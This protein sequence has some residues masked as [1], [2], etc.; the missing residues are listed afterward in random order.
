MEN[1]EKARALGRERAFLLG[2]A[3]AGDFHDAAARL[4]VEVVDPSAPTDDEVRRAALALARLALPATDHLA[5]ADALLVELQA[6]RVPKRSAGLGHIFANAAATTPADVRYKSLIM[7]T[8][9]RC[10]APQQEV[11]VFE[12]RYCKGP[13]A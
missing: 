12:C 1:E 4:G 2:A 11:C 10:G 7:V 8:C 5:F 3:H 9:S 6:R 13:V